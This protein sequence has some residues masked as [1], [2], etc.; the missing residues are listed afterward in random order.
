[1]RKHVVIPAV[2]LLA[3]SFPGQAQDL[4]GPPPPPPE[5]TPPVLHCPEP[6]YDWGTV[7]TGEEVEHAF[8]IENRG[9]SVLKIEN[10]RTSCGCTTA[11]YDKEIPPGGKG[12]IV[13]RIRTR[14]F[15][16]RVRKTATITT[17]DPH[18]KTFKLS[19]GGDIKPVVKFD[20][21]YPMMEGLRGETLTTKVRITRELEGRLEILS[22][23]STGSIKTTY[24]LKEVKPGDI[25]DLT[26][27]VTPSTTTRSYY[28]GMPVRLTIKVRIEG[29]EIDVPLNARLKLVDTVNVSKKY[30]VFRR[31]EVDAFLKNGS[32]APER[33]L[34]VEGYKGR[35]FKITGVEVKAR[36]IGVRPD[37]EVIEKAPLE[38]AVEPTESPSKYKL[39]VTL[40]KVPEEKRRTMSCEILIRTDDEKTPE[41]K[42]R[43]T[44][45]FPWKSSPY[46]RSTLRPTG[47]RRS[48]PVRAR[49]KGGSGS[50][51]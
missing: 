21:P 26:L 4:Y 31:N 33:M 32:K 29:K 18:N 12:E 8:R 48:P 15:T 11:R 45:Y 50:K 35:T 20:P 17:N 49:S 13:L 6:N 7:L 34:T 40:L 38:V 46:T 36:K 51:K 1:M 39:R 3:A 30:V 2:F 10:V 9:G 37:S 14:G 22:V 41:I 25:F 44:V 28:Y 23:K 27:H 16:H 24:E 47:S 43:A 42:V 19:I 5:I